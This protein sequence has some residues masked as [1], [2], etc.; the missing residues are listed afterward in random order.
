MGQPLLMNFS[1]HL[2]TGLIKTK[3]SKKKPLSGN[4]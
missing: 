3:F 1:I 4:I 2:F